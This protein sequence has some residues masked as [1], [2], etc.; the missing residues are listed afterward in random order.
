MRFEFGNIRG[1]T[2]RYL[3]GGSGSPLLLVH[4]VGMSADSWFRNVPAL[5]QRFRVVAPDLLDNGFTGSGEYVGGPPHPYI[6]DRLLSLADHA[7]F[8]KFSL[9]GSSLGSLISLLTYFKAPERVE[10]LVLVG[11]AHLLGAPP[12][13]DDP[14]EASY[15]N[16]KSALM[17]PTYDSCRTRMGR[18]VFDPAGVPDVLIAMQM[19]MYAQPDALERFERRMAGLRSPE[20]AKYS[21]HERLNEIRVPTAVICGCE[22]IRG[23]YDKVATDAARIPGAKLIPYEKCGHWPHMEHP[24][25]FNRDIS[26]FLSGS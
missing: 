21:V 4:G 19:M 12:T 26:D 3:S 16:G 8:E 11:P 2:T 25:R 18:A 9:V 1:A 15:R 10:K 22:D 24:D 7:G 20:A 6:V 14:L 23:S 13:G 5:S 17:S